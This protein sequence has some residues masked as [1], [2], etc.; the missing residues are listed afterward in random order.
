MQ[1]AQTHSTIRVRVSESSFQIQHNFE[2]SG[3]ILAAGGAAL[4]AEALQKRN[5]QRFLGTSFLD[6]S[7]LRKLAAAAAERK[8]LRG[9]DAIISSSF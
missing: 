2:N 8:V 1:L 4:A 9:S 3:L 6:I 5:L 7:L